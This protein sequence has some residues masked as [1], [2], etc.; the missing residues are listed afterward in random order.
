MGTKLE[1]ERNALNAELEEL[2][3]ELETERNALKSEIDAAKKTTESV[4]IDA[5]KIKVKYEN[6]IKDIKTE[7][8][9]EKKELND[10]IDVMTDKLNEKRDSSQGTTIKLIELE[11][12][13]GSL[14]KELKEK[15]KYIEELG[16]VICDKNAEILELE[17]APK[18]QPVP[19]PADTTDSG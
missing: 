10:R 1:T 7:T 15:D 14:E 8:E 19:A 4:K 6:Q 16:D 3:T 11:G 18:P 2:K 13:V 12:R 17:N 5:D 9:K